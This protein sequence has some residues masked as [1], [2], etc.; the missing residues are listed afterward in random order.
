MKAIRPQDIHRFESNP[1][2]PQN[3]LVSGQ[4]GVLFGCQN[5]QC[6]T[7]IFAYSDGEKVTIREYQIGCGCIGGC[8]SAE[9]RRSRAWNHLRVE[10]LLGEDVK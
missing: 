5:P 4:K 3:I 7:N 9:I 10:G 8:E 1:Y 6:G 2:V